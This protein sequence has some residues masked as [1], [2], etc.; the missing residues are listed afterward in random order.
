M[1]MLKSKLFLGVMF[2]TIAIITLIAPNVVWF[3]LN[4]ATYFE[5]GVDKLSVGAMLTVFYM[6]LMVKGAFK[7]IDKRFAT[8]INLFLILAIT[9]FFESVINDLF[10][11]ILCG[12]IGYAFYLV[13]SSIGKRYMNY[14]NAVTDE[15]ARVYARNEVGN[16]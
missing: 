2:H 13:F 7:D 3:Y 9:W 15:R 6:L 4:R 1:M 16:V 8:F 11:I 12:N 10:W 5:T 14:H